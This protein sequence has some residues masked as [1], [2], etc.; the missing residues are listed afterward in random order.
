MELIFKGDYFNDQKAQWLEK[1][2]KQQDTLRHPLRQVRIPRR[3]ASEGTI[4]VNMEVLYEERLK[5]IQKCVLEKAKI[6]AANP[7]YDQPILRE[8][9]YSSMIWAN[10]DFLGNPDVESEESKMIIIEDETQEK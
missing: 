1:Y 3:R 7:G 6:L 10:Y 4:K 5:D 8:R 2:K 9:L